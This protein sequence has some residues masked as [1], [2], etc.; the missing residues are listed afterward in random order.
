M[1]NFTNT[2]NWLDR[3]PTKHEFDDLEELEKLL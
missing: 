3:L 2:D 1:L